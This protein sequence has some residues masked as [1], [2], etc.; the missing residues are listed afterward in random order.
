[1]ASHS[2]HLLIVLL[3]LVLS[4][5]LQALVIHRA[6]APSLD[7]VRFA[8]IARAMDQQGLVSVLTTEH[9][10]PLFPLWVS[11]VHRWQ[12][13]VTGDAP[14]SW[15][16]SVQLA[17]SISAVFCVVPLY[18]MLLRLVGTGPATAA[19]SLFCILP[20]VAR[21]G[22]DGISDST[23]LLLLCIALCA[24]VHWLT[25]RE[26]ELPCPQSPIPSLRATVHHA[27]N[28]GACSWF[29]VA[30]L[31]TGLALLTRK[32]SLVLIVA[33][34]IALALLQ[35]SPHRRLPWA[36]LARA[37]S[38]YILGMALALAP[39][40]LAAW[41]GQNTSLA[42]GAIADSVVAPVP[43]PDGAGLLPGGEPM[44]FAAKEPTRSIRHRGYPAAAMRLVHKL[45]DGFGYWIGTLA[46]AGLWWR[47]QHAARDVDGFLGIFF[48][49]FSAAAL[50]FSATEG[51]LEA[52]HLLALVAV[53]MGM[54]GYGA[55]ELGRRLARSACPWPI[56]G[57]PTRLAWIVVVLAAAACLPQT[58][59]PLHASRLGD[60]AAAEWLQSHAGPRE[61]ILDTQGWTLLYSDRLA[62]RFDDG[63]RAL[64]DPRLAYVV[65]QPKETLFDSPRSRTLRHLAQKCGPPVATFPNPGSTVSKEHTV[66][67]YKWRR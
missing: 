44:S 39:H 3:L 34:A 13:C 51:Y 55:W 21:L 38:C 47:R 11:I 67:V 63:P 1:M 10:H 15:A 54:S 23:H 40:G 6:A 65:L 31:A 35:T 19:A 42:N 8:T 62:Y 30:G 7:A 53:G 27:P 56:A 25:G 49:L 46:L 24:I 64:A 61:A 16:T 33:L 66:A 29:A 41:P 52:R 28:R 2:R 43:S 26:S 45:A 18:F 60:R 50:Q 14:S 36:V 59:R 22:A 20:E 17:A 58:L 57:H 48:A 37:S 32:E 9:E 4:S 12:V 5:L